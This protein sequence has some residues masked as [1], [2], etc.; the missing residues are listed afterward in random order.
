VQAHGLST[1]P[2]PLRQ[3]TDIYERFFGTANPLSVALLPTAEELRSEPQPQGASPTPAALQVRIRV[4]LEELYTGAERRVSYLRRGPAGQPPEERS[5]PVNVQPGWADGTRLTFRGEGDSAA[6][7]SS[8]GDL[9]VVVDEVEHSRFRRKGRDLH[10]T[11]S[12]TLASALLGSVVEVPTLDGRKLR[13]PVHEIA[14]PHLQK[15]VGGEGLPSPQGPGDLVIWFEI[16]FP[17]HL[18]DHQRELLRTALVDE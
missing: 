1:P 8:R 2:L 11:A 14:S 16:D 10:F 13:I 9:V 18:R 4:T 7:G 5:V 12:V 3:A 17:K 6:D 15:V